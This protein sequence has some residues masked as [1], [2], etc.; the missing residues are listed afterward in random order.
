MLRAQKRFDARN[1]GAKGTLMVVG[2]DDEVAAEKVLT[3]ETLANSESN[4][5]PKPVIEELQQAARTIL[6]EVAA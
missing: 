6:F 3:Q 4:T 5:K 1:L 2:I